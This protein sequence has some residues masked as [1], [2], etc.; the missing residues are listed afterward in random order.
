MDLTVNFYYNGRLTPIQCKDNEEMVSVFGK[1]VSKL[2]NG[3]SINDYEFYNEE[4]EEIGLESTLAK[5]LKIQESS[6]TISVK[7][8]I[9]FC[10]C[11]ECK[12]N[13]CIVNLSN[14]LCAFYGCKYYKEKNHEVITVYDNYKAKQTINYSE[15]RCHGPECKKN[16]GNDKSD[17]YK[18]LDCSKLA[19]MS[20]YYCQK[21][22]SDHNK[23]QKHKFIKY[24]EKHYY[25]D[26]HLEPFEKSCLTCKKDLCKYCEGEHSGHEVANYTD[27]ETNVDNLKASLKKIKDH[28]ETLNK[29]IENIKYHLDG[30]KRIYERY[31]NI[32]SD[33]LKK[34]ETFNKNLKNY[35]ILRTIR[36]LKISNRQILGDLEKIINNDDLKSKSSTIIEI[37]LQKKAA[38]EGAGNLSIKDV[39]KESNDTWYEEIL[40]NRNNKNNKNREGQR[41]PNQNTTKKK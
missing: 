31:Y 22:K 2:N 24:D 29:V 15:I 7:R 12:C 37:Y 16:L 23:E 39:Q 19:K 20:K 40:K 28:I 18:C 35:R 3:A 25:C 41:R 33:I 6:V 13:D 1:F 32:S 27:M 8:K 17:F 26:E 11:P 38:Y 9:K 21:C 14:Y 10:K 30:T 36:N 5:N 4:E 34:Y